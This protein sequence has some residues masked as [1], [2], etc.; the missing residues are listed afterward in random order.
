[1]KLIRLAGALVLALATSSLALAQSPTVL[2]MGYALSPESH[3]GAGAKA[4]AEKLT[5]LTNGRYQIQQF[6]NSALGGERETIEQ[7]QLGTLDLVSVSTGPVSNFVPDV[8]IT[9]KVIRRTAT[10][11]GIISFVFNTALI[12]LMVNIAGSAI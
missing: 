3:Y 6:P 12:A 10:V 2:K 7:V 5:E 4:F 11:H 9:D 1:M 8:G